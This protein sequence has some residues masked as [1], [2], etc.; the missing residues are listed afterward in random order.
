ML[1]AHGLYGHIRNNDFRAS[2]LMMGFALYAGLLWLAA[3]L[4]VSGVGLELWV[5]NAQLETNRQ[6]QEPHWLFGLHTAEHIAVTY[7][8]VPVVLLAGW[9]AYA[10]LERKRMTREATGAEPTSRS[11]EPK[12]CN[13]VETLAIAA[14][15]PT[16][17]VEIIETNALN[18][19]ASG[20]TPAD[21]SVAVTRGLLNDLSKDELEAVLAHEITHIRYRDVRLM[22]VAAIFVG[23]FVSVGRTLGATKG[24]GANRDLALRTSGGVGI[25]FALA[26]IVAG[27]IASVLAVL[28]ELALSRTR[29]FVADAGAVALTKNADALIRALQ[30][31][32]AHGEMPAVARPFRAMMIFS[33]AASWWS[34]HPSIESRIA[35][36]EMY[37]GGRRAF[38]APPTPVTEP[39]FHANAATS[40]QARS[41]APRTFGRRATVP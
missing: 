23:F 32:A 12:L 19:Y 16:P 39:G 26:A 13:M 2:V 3:C 5:V 36:L 40:V 37:A 1:A 38:V 4:L 35:A 27:A 31:I 30:K 24:D 33:P 41:N 29:E 28:S 11:L 9:L 8:W 7:A 15:L 21:S 25:F 22:T 20:W 6:L 14:G 17:T 34:T 10:F 18:A